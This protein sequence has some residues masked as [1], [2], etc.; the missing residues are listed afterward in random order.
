[1]RTHYT[2]GLSSALIGKVVEVTGSYDSG[3]MVV[4]VAGLLN[5]I[6]LGL[7]YRRIKY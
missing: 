4:V 2:G 6:V 7:L 1:M 5:A 3:L